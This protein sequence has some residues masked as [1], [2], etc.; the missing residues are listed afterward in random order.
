[1]HRRTF[2]KMLGEACAALSVVHQTAGAQGP[3]LPT[4]AGV[5]EPSPYE[6]DWA[7][8]S[9]LLENASTTSTEPWDDD[10]CRTLM[11][12][13]YLGNGDFGTHLGGTVHCLTYYLGKNG[14]HAGNDVAAGRYNQHILNLA[15]LSIEAAAGVESAVESAPAYRVSQDIRNAEIRTECILAGAAVRTRAY[16]SPTASALVVELFTDSGQDV[17]LQATLSVIGNSFMSR[18]RWPPRCWAPRRSPP[19]TT[20]LPPDWLS[21]CPPA[22][23]Q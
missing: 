6:P 12:G 22:A 2:I 13:A 1:M 10:P 16:L 17:Q 18:G 23:R 20:P 9:A 8:V 11:K 4:A 3:Q 21:R 5:P 14:F 7:T 15:I 19:A